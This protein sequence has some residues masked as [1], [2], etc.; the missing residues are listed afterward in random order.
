MIQVLEFKKEDLKEICADPIDETITL[1]FAEQWAKVCE[2]GL[3][4]TAMYEG[5]AVGMVGI[6]INRPGVGNIWA[7]LNRKIL[8]CKKTLLRSMKTMLEDFILPATHLKLRALSRQDFPASQRLLEHLKF[9]KKGTFKG[10]Y[11]YVRDYEK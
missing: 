9:V 7:M 5:E 6:I 2:A 4:Y 3:S 10:Y 1:E 11:L 8:K